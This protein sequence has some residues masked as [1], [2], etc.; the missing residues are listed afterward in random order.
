MYIFDQYFTIKTSTK[1]RLIRDFQ[2]DIEDKNVTIQALKKIT[3]ELN[4]FLTHKEE[5]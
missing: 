2:R 4:D 3:I 5:L 1:E